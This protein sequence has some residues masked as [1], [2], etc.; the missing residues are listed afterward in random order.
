M[1]GTIST[2]GWLD[3]TKA[4]D[5]GNGI[6]ND[7]HYFNGYFIY[8]AAGTFQSFNVPNFKSEF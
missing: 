2:E 4:V 3:K 6:Y 5:F 7:H 1:E 8:A